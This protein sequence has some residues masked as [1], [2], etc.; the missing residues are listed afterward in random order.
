[1]PGA[2][3]VAELTSSGVTVTA[4]SPV[5]VLGVNVVSGATLTVTT[6]DF[7]ATEGT[8]TGA[9][10]GLIRVAGQGGSGGQ[11]NFGGTLP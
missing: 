5:T 6:P 3:D 10:H 11:L 7:T 9:N 2:G 4:N 8:A 1:M